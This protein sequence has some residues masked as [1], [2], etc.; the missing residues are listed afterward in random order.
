MTKAVSAATGLSTSLEAAIQKVKVNTLL[1]EEGLGWVK[2]NFKERDCFWQLYKTHPRS[3]ASPKQ[4]GNYSNRLQTC[5]IK[6]RYPGRSG[7]SPLDQWFC[8]ASISSCQC[9]SG[10]SPRA[11]VWVT[12]SSSVEPSQLSVWAQVEEKMNFGKIHDEL[13]F[14]HFGGNLRNTVKWM[15]NSDNQRNV[16]WWEN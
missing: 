12:A 1:Q 5:S 3:T 10:W 6:T 13:L 8:P 2:V 9:R 7:Q 16:N 4:R 14:R 11:A 15:Q